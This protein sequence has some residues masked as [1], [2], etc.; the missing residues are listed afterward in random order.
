MLPPLM[1]IGPGA[2]QLFVVRQVANPFPCRPPTPSATLTTDG[3]TATHFALA[4]TSGGIVLSGSDITSVSTSA[5]VCR[6]FCISLD[7]FSAA[8]AASRKP[9]MV[10]ATATYKTE[11]LKICVMAPDSE[12]QLSD[13][14]GR[15]FRCFTGSH[16]SLSLQSTS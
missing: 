15:A 10:I 12:L 8:Q 11:T 4:R 16:V 5:E 9:G 2:L 6:R 14:P 1:L 13:V 7:A 3:I